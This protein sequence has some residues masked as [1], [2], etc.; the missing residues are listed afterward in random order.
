MNKKPLI[1]VIVPC[2]NVEKYLCR[3]VDSI[4]SQSYSN[5]EV[6]LVDDGS[7]DVSGKICDEYALKD[8]RIKVIHKI[9]GGL[10]DARNVALDVAKGELI[11]FVDSDD[12][13]DTDYVGYLYSM[14]IEHGADVSVIN[15]KEVLETDEN[16]SNTI[17]RKRYLGVFDR[18]QAI[19][20]MFYQEKFDTT[21]H[22]KMYK[23]ELFSTLRFPKGKIFEDL[24][25]IYQIFL[26]SNRIVV[27]SSQLYFYYLRGDSIEGESFS[28]KKYKDAMYIY[29]QIMS[30]ERLFSIADAVTCRMF[31]FLFRLYLSMPKQDKRRSHLWGE[32][33]AMRTNVLFNSK[34]RKKARIAAL[35]SYAGSDIISF[36]YKQIK[37]R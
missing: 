8:R 32:L 35:L 31:S 23:R 17:R 18:Y 26:L 1:S 24:A 27:S 29:S 15:F 21:A 6:I 4:L 22:C 33:C 12:W 16:K 2:Y 11:T 34:S 5:L 9:N 3:C 25:L 14:L 13:L 30:D 10:S 20:A 7:P 36:V 37:K 28:E 19:E